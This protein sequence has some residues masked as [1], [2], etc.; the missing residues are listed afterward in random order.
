[1]SEA[2]QGFLLDLDQGMYPY[3]TSS[4]TT[5][6]GVCSGLGIHTSYV[7]HVTGVAKAVQSHVGGGPFINRDK[8]SDTARSSAWKYER[9]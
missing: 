1:L 3:T 2:A 9:D 6:G 8:G 7:R 4:S 5:A